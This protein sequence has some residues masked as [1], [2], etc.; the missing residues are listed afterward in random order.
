MIR[1]FLHHSFIFKHVLYPW[2][3]YFHTCHF[4][5]D[6]FISISDFFYTWFICFYIIHFHRWF[7][8]RHSFIFNILPFVPFYL[9]HDSLVFMCDI[10]RTIHL[11]SHVMCN[12]F[13]IYHI[14]NVFLMMTKITAGARRWPEFHLDQVRVRRKTSRRMTSSFYVIINVIFKS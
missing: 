6:S 4:I 10:L 1:L 3:T 13:W 2:F 8:L 14:W 5:Y 7:S 12:G 11:F 9:T